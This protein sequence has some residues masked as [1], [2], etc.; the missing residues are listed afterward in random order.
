MATNTA[1]YNIIKPDYTDPVD[2]QIL[3]DNYDLIDNT[4]YGKANLVDGKVPASELPSYV[5]DIIEGYYYNGAFYSDSGHST[6]ITGETGKIYV[7]LS[8][9]K[10]Y[11]WSGSVYVQI[12][13]GA[14]EDVQDPQG[15]S[16]VNNG[17][18]V[19][20]VIDIE[21]E[22]GN[23]LV[24]SNG[25]AVI[26]SASVLAFQLLYDDQTGNLTTSLTAGEF[27][28]AVAAGK[29]LIGIYESSPGIYTTYNVVYVDTV[30]LE[31][32]VCD[33][34][35]TNDWIMLAGDVNSPYEYWIG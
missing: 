28:A 29:V 31:I 1:H 8:T 6:P 33:I 10:Q 11:R 5:D 14:V 16:L 22:D 3:D 18:A 23:S 4:L 32:E 7:D 26:P 2:V 34:N 24:D 20:P 27:N 17:I 19:I 30:N 13:A 15:N 35:L 12:A 25:T 21:D 9:N